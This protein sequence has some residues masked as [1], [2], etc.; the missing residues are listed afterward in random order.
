VGSKKQLVYR[1]SAWGLEKNFKRDERREILE[2][3]GPELQTL[4]ESVQLKGQR[5]EKSKLDRWKR[6]EKFEIGGS[7]AKIT[8]IEE[9]S[10]GSLVSTFSLWPD[11]LTWIQGFP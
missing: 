1:V 2:R 11:V 4:G 6:M 5:V 7:A 10:R 3:L 9:V 8:N